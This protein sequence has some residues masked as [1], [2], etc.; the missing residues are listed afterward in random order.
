MS[1]KLLRTIEKYAQYHPTALSLQ[2]F[3]EFG[4]KAGSGTGVF[5]P[6]ETHRIDK[7][8]GKVEACNKTSVKFLKKEIPV[9]LA[10]ILEELKHL[11]KPLLKSPSM[12]RITQWYQQSFEEVIEYENA[13]GEN[14][15][16]QMQ[17]SETL[18]SIARRHATVVETT[19]EGVMEYRDLHQNDSSANYQNIQYFLDRFYM[20]RISIRMLINQH[21]MLFGDDLPKSP[22]HIG[23]IDP[24]C[25]VLSVAKDS[26]ANA[27]FLCEQ[28][29]MTSPSVE[30]TTINPYGPDSSTSINLVYVPSH[31]YYILFELFK[32]SMRA[33]VEKNR[34]EDNDNFEPIKCLI[35]R[36]HEDVVIRISDMGGGIRRSQTHMLFNYMYST[37]PRPSMQSG[38]VSAPLAGYGYGLPVSRLYARYLNG[39]LNVVTIDGYGTDAIVTLKLLSSQAN[40]LL[41]IYTAT[42]SK[43]Y[44]SEIPVADWS[45]SY[46][47]R[48]NNK[49]PN[50]ST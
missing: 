48:N 24:K 18:S 40:E 49:R 9:R 6:H 5:L 7:D 44:K 41:P 21:T 50:D 25:D 22:T 45:S 42:T 39:D 35:C 36:G 26:Y 4:A 14:R 13:D 2:N 11:P 34:D 19:A 31:L 43:Q 29:Y 37:A 20:S 15:D 16:V 30:Y 10:N 28:Y 27:K 46:P 33:V 8:T 32:N 38:S 3:I 47:S 17:F 1:S 12:R 23:C